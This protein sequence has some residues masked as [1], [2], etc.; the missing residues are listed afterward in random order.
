M[1]QVWNPST[2]EA[3]EK[4]GSEVQGQPWL[5]ETIYKLKSLHVSGACAGDIAPGVPPLLGKA[6]QIKP[7]FGFEQKRISG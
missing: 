7:N 1:V 2:Q 3:A 6:S 4:I 5:H